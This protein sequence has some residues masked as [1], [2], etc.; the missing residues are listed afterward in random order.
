MGI[1]TLDTDLA[2]LDG[3]Q[4]KAW[5]TEFG[6]LVENAFADC[7]NRQRLLGNL[8]VLTRYKNTL[9]QGLWRE[10]K[11]LSPGLES[12][13]ELLWDFLEKN[14]FPLNFADFSNCL[15]ECHYINSVGESDELPEPFY[16]E[17]FGNGYPCAYEWM[18]VE[19][20]SGLLM[21]LV[22]IA[23]GRLDF[24]DFEDCEHVDFYGV[25]LLLD[26]LAAIDE[27]GEPLPYQE[28][29]QIVKND[30][31]RARNSCPEVFGFLRTEY[32]NDALM[33][34]E[35]AEKLLNY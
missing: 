16:S 34:E 15:Y 25:H 21:Q 6:N 18:A 32:Q 8:L 31:Q 35:D 17:N 2:A 29:A 26:Q 3:P 28:I 19:W 10:G 14:A 9:R 22:A 27:G 30:L 1:F 13:V 11:L 5:L 33:S 20:A 7:D 12:A 23:G 24:D 4:V